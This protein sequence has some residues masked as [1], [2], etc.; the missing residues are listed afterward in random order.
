MKEVRTNIKSTLQLGLLIRTWFYDS[1]QLCPS[2]L[3]QDLN[4]CELTMEVN[5]A[6]VRV[7][8]SAQMCQTESW[9]SR[10]VSLYF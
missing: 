7:G 2:S 10:E 9:E 6:A 4:I 5:S 3:T 1:E 8:G